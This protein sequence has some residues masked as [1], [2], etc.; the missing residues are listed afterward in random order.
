MISTVKWLGF[1]PKAT[2]YIPA[3]QES[4]LACG[5]LQVYIPECDITGERLLGSVALAWPLVCGGKIAVTVAHHN[6]EY[7]EGSQGMT[8]N[9]ILEARSD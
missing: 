2:T 8:G 1:P 6:S 4:T 7:G 5:T 9:L 3:T